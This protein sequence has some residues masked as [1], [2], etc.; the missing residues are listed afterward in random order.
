MQV[1]GSLC[2]GIPPRLDHAMLKLSFPRLLAAI[3]VCHL[4][5]TNV[6]NIGKV[7]FSIGVAG[8]RVD[9]EKKLKPIQFFIGQRGASDEEISRVQKSSG[10]NFSA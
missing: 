8:L 4:H 5:A 10:E 1:R 7:E 6:P 9:L 2:S 3:R